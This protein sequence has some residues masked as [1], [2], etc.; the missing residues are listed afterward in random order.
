MSSHLT[1]YF[2]IIF[3]IYSSLQIPVY[4]PHNSMIKYFQFL[5]DSDVKY[6]IIRNLQ[7]YIIFL[8]IIDVFVVAKLK[9]YN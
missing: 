5:K 2:I 3:Q 9:S 7:K 1:S 6:W 4:D 8:K